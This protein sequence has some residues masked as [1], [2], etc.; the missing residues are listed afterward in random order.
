ME[1][2]WIA[3]TKKKACQVRSNVKVL[4]TVFLDYNGVVH[5]EFLPEGH[6]ANKEYYLED[7]HHLHEAIWKKYPEL[8]KNKSWLLH[9]GIVPAHMSLLV[10]HV[11]ANNNTI[12]MPQP[13]YSPDLAPWLFPVSKTE[14]THKRTEIC[15]DWEIKTASLEELKTIPKSASSIG[16]RAGTSVLYLRGITWKGTI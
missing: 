11:L 13:P 7:M 6:T 14:E 10:H 5:Y 15:Y 4:L 16:K 12:I 2:L 8:W 3:K 9:H 1:A